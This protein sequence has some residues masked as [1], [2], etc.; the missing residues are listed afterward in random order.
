VDHFVAISTVVQERIA[1]R[2]G[3]EST[4]IFPPAELGGLATDRPPEDFYLILGR[5]VPYKRI[6]LAVEAFNRL[7][8]PLVVIGDG[9]DRP[10]LEALAGPTVRF[11]G[12]RSRDEVVDW[13]RRC[14]GLVWPGVE[15]YGLAPVEAMAAGRPVVARRAGGVL[16]TVVDGVTGV[17]FDAADPAAIAAAVRRAEATAWDAA[18]IRAQARRFGRDVFEA[19]LEA[20]LADV[21]GRRRATALAPLAA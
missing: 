15:D 10:R 12:R 3:R 11:L 5:L 8:R 16:D 6:D 9:R 1:Q 21:Q 14:R 4:V 20:F 2:Y 13:L 7:G 17:F 18:A 19:R